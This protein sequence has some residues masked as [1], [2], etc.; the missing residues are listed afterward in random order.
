MCFLHATEFKEDVACFETGAAIAGSNQIV[1]ETAHRA[2]VCLFCVHSDDGGK[3]ITLCSMI[4]SGRYESLL[5][6]AFVL[7]LALNLSRLTWNKDF[8]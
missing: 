3:R 6:N 1:D 2:L 4:G 7:R 5:R 8:L